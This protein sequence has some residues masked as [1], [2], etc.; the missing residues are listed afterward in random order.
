MNI[1][2]CNIPM[3]DDI[4]FTNV[5]FWLL[6]ISPKLINQNLNHNK[7]CLHHFALQ[8]YFTTIRKIMKYGIY[9]VTQM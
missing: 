4:I 2:I 1:F 6:L 9:L 8:H 3:T 5:K 7:H